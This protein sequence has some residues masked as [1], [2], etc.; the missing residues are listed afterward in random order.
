VRSPVDR[1]TAG[2][3]LETLGVEPGG[4]HPAQT[5]RIE[6]VWRVAT[7]F[8][9]GWK[10]G[11]RLRDAQGRAWWASD[12]GLDAGWLGTEPP[13]EGDRL[14]TRAAITLPADAP[15]GP[16]DLEVVVYRSTAHPESGEGWVAWSAPP[17]LLPLVSAPSREIAAARPTPR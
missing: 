11:L 3:A 1:T 15:A 10:A 16:Y 17:V 8:E 12:P 6:L 7:A 2:V 14:R 5:T 9:S 13:A 4:P